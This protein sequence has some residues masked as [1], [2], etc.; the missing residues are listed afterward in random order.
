VNTKSARASLLA[1]TATTAVALASL[2]AAPAAAQEPGTEVQELVVT[3]SRIP[4][5]N[6]DQPTPVG[7]LKVD[8]QRGPLALGDVIARLPQA[9][10]SGTARANSNNFGT[11]A[12]LNAV[13]L[14]N[15]GLSRTLVLVDGQRHVAGDLQSNAVDVNSIPSALIDR[16]EVITGGAS[17]I[18]GSDA[19]TGVVNIIT[20]KQFQGL[21]LD[22]S[23][24]RYDAGFGGRYSASATAGRN[25]LDDRL[26]LTVSGFWRKDSAIDASD[27]P[28]ANN[29]QTINNP[30]D[31]AFG[32]RDPSF[33][34][35]FRFSGPTTLNNGVPDKLFVPNVGSELTTRNGVLVNAL[36]GSAIV[37]DAAGNPVAT[38]RRTGYNSFAYGQL[39]NCA[40]CSYP[41][42]FKEVASQIETGGFAFKASYDFTPKIRGFIDAKFVENSVENNFQPSFTAGDYLLMPDN[43]YLT[44]AIGGAIFQDGGQFYVFSRW[45]N[46]GRSQDIRR[47]TYRAVAGL[48]GDWDADFAAVKWDASLNYGETGVDIRYH[49]VMITENFA[50]ALDSVID[51][52]TG[53]PACRINVPSAGVSPLGYGAGALNPSTCT[54]YNPFGLQN[55]AA[56]L[57]YSFGDFTTKDRLTQ[58]VASVNASFDTS[59]FLKLPGGPVGVATGA[60][61]RMERI[62]DRSDPLLTSGATE[63]AATDSAGGFNVVEGYLELNAPIFRDAG[64]LM[65]ELSVDAA[66]RGADYSTV[67]KVA[68]YKVGGVYGPASWLKFRGTWSRSV[69]APNITEAY[70]PLTS[71][72]FIIKDPCSVEHIG[73]N[74][75]FARNCAA[76]GLPANFV[77]TTN[78]GVPGT[79]SGN[80]NLDPEK[81]RSWTVGFVVQPPMVRNLAIT[82]DYYAIRIKD[83]ITSVAAQ[84]VVDNCYASSAG[85]DPTYCSLFTRTGGPRFAITGVQTTY[86]NAAKLFT[87]GFELQVS[88]ATDVGALTQGWGPASALD[89]RLSFQLTADYVVSLRNYPFQSNPSD[90]NVLEGTATTLFGNNPQLKAIA[91]VSYS[92]GPVTVGWTTR[93]IGR[94]ALFSRD[95]SATQGSESLNI[96]FTEPT[97]YHDLMVSYRMEGGLSGLEL[98]AGAQ[99]L[100]DEEPPFT[101]LGSNRDAAFDLGRFLYVGARFRR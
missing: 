52:A 5:P 56:A 9:G 84:D 63:N 91:D 23:G 58:Q 92:Q 31:L 94:Q 49:N 97:F 100:F 55:S 19:V 8:E 18:Y 66:W 28:A 67:G 34:T 88:Y 65:D 75:N 41:E 76:A 26:N 22:V 78:A 42:D 83:A 81:S 27:V 2:I 96:P 72:P 12:G 25:F 70:A 73:D 74:V 30:A 10:F 6:L 15:L 80:A 37:F 17:A 79:T 71:S 101:V 35:G 61:Y 38:P 29:Y 20:K 93:Y 50:A 4:R 11:S 14:R 90:V 54:P 60:E 39:S 64:P 33:F 57:A 69:R 44:P 7:V 62:H 82:L 1:T 43:A 3:G 32:A 59:K 68:A 86:V 99:N 47:R 53:R 16:V 21:D 98:Y 51:P 36:T 77:A 46:N 13:N 85:L 87:D 24:G 95:P 40:V 89:G 45:L 48:E